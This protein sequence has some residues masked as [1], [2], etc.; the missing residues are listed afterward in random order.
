[1]G[2]GALRVNTRSAPSLKCATGSSAT[3]SYF[4]SSAGST[5]TKKLLDDVSM[6]GMTLRV[7][8]SADPRI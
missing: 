6:K 1:M 3:F 5:A 4:P 7:T 2:H 8:P